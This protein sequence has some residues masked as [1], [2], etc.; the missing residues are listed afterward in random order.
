MD[1]PKASISVSAVIQCPGFPPITHYTQ[2]IPDKQV[3][4]LSHLRCQKVT[5]P[6]GKQ[7]IWFFQAEWIKSVSLT[8][9][10]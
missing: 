1:S 8:L 5:S 3:R 2:E 4:E 6:W 9:L 10:C 7:M